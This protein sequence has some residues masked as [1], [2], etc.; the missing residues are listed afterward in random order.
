MLYLWIKKKRDKKLKNLIFQSCPSCGSK[1]IKEFN[2]TTKKY[3]AVRRC[4]NE[5][6]GC[7]KIAIEKIKHFISKEALNID[8]LGKKVIEKF[9]DLKLLNKPQDIFN[10]NYI[11]VKKI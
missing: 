2:N 11:K 10:F 9:W 6:F 8:G 5:G 4:T 7:E 1:T 3:D